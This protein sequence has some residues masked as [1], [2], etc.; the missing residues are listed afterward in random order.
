MFSFLFIGLNNTVGESRGRGDVTIH[1]YTNLHQPDITH[2]GFNN[3]SGVVTGGQP[4]TT[5]V[6]NTNSNNKVNNAN[7]NTAAQQFFSE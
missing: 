2:G 3:G 5:G 4:S 1:Q 6:G 7:N